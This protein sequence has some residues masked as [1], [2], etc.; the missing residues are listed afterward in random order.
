MLKTLIRDKFHIEETG[1]IADAVNETKTKYS[2][3]QIVNALAVI[4]GIIWGKETSFILKTITDTDRNTWISKG[5]P[6]TY[7]Y[8]FEALIKSGLAAMGIEVTKKE[9]KIML[10][11]GST[12]TWEG[13]CGEH[14]DSYN[15]AWSATAYLRMILML[16]IGEKA[17]GDLFLR[18][19]FF[20][21]SGIP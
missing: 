20:S 8:V 2:Y 17:D 16:L 11:R 3:S 1:L 10:E 13:F 7:F 9:W 4:T 6:Y 15:H 19:N 21:F 5:T 14:H 18:G 12:T